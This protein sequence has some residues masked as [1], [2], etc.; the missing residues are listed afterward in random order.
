MNDRFRAELRT[1]A[2]VGVVLA[3]LPTLILGSSYYE[4]LIVHVVLIAM[5]A[6]ALNIVFGHTD[7]LF[8][9]MGALAGFGAYGTALLSDWLAIT[10]WVTLPIAAVIAGLIGLAVSW[11]S[12][13]REFTVV[14]ISIL[15]LNLQL[16][17]IE[18]YFGARNITGGST[19][20]SYDYLSLE[21]VP[22]LLGVSE[23]I[24]LFY[25]V[26]LL[27][28]ATLVAYLRLIHSRFGVAFDAIREDEVAA[29]SIGINVVY[30]KS[31]AGFVSAF[32][33]AITGAFLA[34][35]SGF[36]LPGNFTFLQVDV[37]VL[38][39]LVFGGLRT[40]T[41][42]VVGAGLIIG[43]EEILSTYAAQ[44]RTPI[45]GG[46]LIILFLYFRQGIVRAAADRLSNL[47]F[48]PTGKQAD[49][50]PEPDEGS[51]S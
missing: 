46:L 33:F 27:L 13:K 24:V 43:I 49:Q 39:V 12:A 21:P 3:L 15:T 18:V 44:W 45:F 47:G 14:L 1:V 31:V 17:F 42:P 35:E 9:F 26:V 25:L 16:V 28:V 23:T 2:V 11:I 5:L 38:I 41:G 8:L 37:L 50:E 20:F 48:P 32:L 34:V 7:Q 19:G 22:E 40:T 6:V 36:L 30:Y 51:A 29:R 4:T 10:P